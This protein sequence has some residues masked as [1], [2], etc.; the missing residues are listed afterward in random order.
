MVEKYFLEYCKIRDNIDLKISEILS[1]YKGDILCKKG[2]SGCCM[3]ITLFPVE[4]FAIKQE[5]DKGS[6]KTLLSPSFTLDSKNTKQ[7]Q[8]CIFLEKSI[9]TIY[10]SRP[11]ICRTQGL[12]LFY[13]SDTLEDYTISF[14]DKNFTS[15]R[16]DFEFNT[17]Y[18]IDLDKLNSSLYKLN[19]EF[20]KEINLENNM[21]KRIQISLL[22]SN[23][24]TSASASDKIDYKSPSLY[25]NE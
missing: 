2:C 9:C 15:C 6:L 14:C 8:D 11:I 7:N 20:M 23:N 21:D 10:E 4:F 17:E 3:A 5:T 16:E 19:K 25:F 22:L 1:F 24:N 13:F 18:S 12:P